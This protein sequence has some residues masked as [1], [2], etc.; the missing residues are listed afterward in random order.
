MPLLPRLAGLT[1]VA[2][3]VLA[4]GLALGLSSGANPGF[5]GNTRASDG[6]PRT[7]ATSG[8]HDS[9]DLNAGSG[10]VSVSVVTPT[11]G[12]SARGI[13]IAL[14]AQ[15]PV[16]DG[17]ERTKQG[18]EATI[19]DPQTG[20]VWGTLQLTDP[21]HTRYTAGSEAYVTHTRE[22]NA[23]TSW[24]F[25]WEPG[26]RRGVARLYVTANAGNGDG[27]PGGDYIYAATLDLPVSGT[28]QDAPPE[29]AFSVGDP[30]PNPVRAG[31]VAVLDLA[32]REPGPVS[33][34]VVDG[35]GRTVRH[36]A[37][38]RSTGQTP[39][40]VPTGGLAPGTYFVVVEGPGGRRT[41]PL[42]VAR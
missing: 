24:R 25:D 40:T 11:D 39:V 33:V 5:A 41:L 8:C 32:L 17:A 36:L 38:A 34:R 29:V 35:V 21:T 15:T 26:A 16:A 14:D 42:A 28:A 37:A 2:G 30:R 31:R 9:F 27:S 4:P 22:G 13:E 10:G 18:F 3:I 6:T 20:D 23:Q 19:R 12:S 1:V 7:C